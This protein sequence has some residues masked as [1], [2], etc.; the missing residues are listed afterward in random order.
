M[1][2]AL[3]PS[4]A[5]VSDRLR[6]PKVAPTAVPGQYYYAL[7]SVNT[8][9]YLVFVSGLAH[10]C[11]RQLT[12]NRVFPCHIMHFGD[13]L[14]LSCVGLRRVCATRAGAL[15]VHTASPTVYVYLPLSP[16]PCFFVF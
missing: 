12:T 14:T 2:A 4:E 6:S 10:S 8:A 11:V 15:I 13:T 7:H 3:W 16:F 5:I 1:G 9:M